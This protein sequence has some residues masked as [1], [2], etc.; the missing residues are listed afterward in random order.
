MCALEMYALKMC[1]KL[2]SIGEQF[3]HGIEINII[4]FLD[5]CFFVFGKRERSVVKTR[6]RNLE[7]THVIEVATVQCNL[8]A[9]DLTCVT[10][11]IELQT[12]F[13]GGEIL[14]TCESDKTLA[15]KLDKDGFCNLHISHFYYLFLS[16]VFILITLYYIL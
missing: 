12:I 11:K 8:N 6:K 1:I 7:E 15:T 3:L 5:N 2:S 4:V 14:S 9:I 13:D 16:L 10:W